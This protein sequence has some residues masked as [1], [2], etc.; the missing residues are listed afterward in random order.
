VYQARLI[1]IP[2]LKDIPQ[3]RHLYLSIAAIP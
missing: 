3:T 1:P 2:A